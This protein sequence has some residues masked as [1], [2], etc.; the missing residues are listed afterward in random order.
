MNRKGNI[1]FFPHKNRIRYNALTKFKTSLTNT[2]GAFAVKVP[3]YVVDEVFRNKMKLDI[4]YRNEFVTTLSY[5]NLR[6]HI[7]RVENKVY[8]GVFRKK[9]IT[10]KLTRIEL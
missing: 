1:Q 10:Y 2:T 3:T 4:Y 8:N 7:D 5:D 6:Y 9:Q